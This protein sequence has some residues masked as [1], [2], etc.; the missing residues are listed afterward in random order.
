MSKEVIRK[1]P[2]AKHIVE[3]FLPINQIDSLKNKF[4]IQLERVF[5]DDWRG[6]RH[7]CS[8][9]GYSEP[10]YAG[11]C[12]GWYNGNP[13]VWGGVCGW[14]V[15]SDGKYALCRMAYED[16]HMFKVLEYIPDPQEKLTE[17]F[18]AELQEFLKSL[19][20]QIDE[21][22]Q[23]QERILQLLKTSQ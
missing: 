11:G 12:S 6:V 21:L 3:T 1:T 2:W 14:D 16:Y 10:G 13:L 19:Q 5:R 7:W 23:N 9:E 17:A 20:N 8:K 4:G 15:T 18:P 22:K